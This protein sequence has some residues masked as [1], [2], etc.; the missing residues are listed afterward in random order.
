MNSNELNAEQNNIIDLKTVQTNSIKNLFES[1]KEILTDVNIEFSKQGMKI[2]SMDSPTQTILV[3]LRL[4]HDKF[5]YYYC[6]EKIVI[7]LNLPN[8]FKIIRTITNNDTLSLYIKQDNQNLIGIK[9]ENSEKNYITN[10]FLNLIEVDER[11][12]QIE[13][14]KFESILTMPSNDF[15]KVCRDMLNISDT[16]EIKSIGSQIIFSC[17]GDF[18][19][20]ETVMGETTNGLYYVQSSPDV[21]IIQ[22]YYNLKHLVL[23]AKCTNMCNSLTIYL[24][25][26]Y[27]LVIEFAVGSLGELKLALA[28]KIVLD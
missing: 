28:P 21:N 17:K 26:S 20:Q 1:L 18:A 13:P 11:S 9:I 3:H 25:N 23:F 15:N 4:E 22:G 10:Y 2:I 24:K 16:I 12:I 14:P 8:F 19:E 7:G 27:P 6:K 5:E